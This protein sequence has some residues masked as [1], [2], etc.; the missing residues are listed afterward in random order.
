MKF[1]IKLPFEIMEIIL[2]NESINRKIE[3]LKVLNY[4]IPLIYY[5]KLYLNEINNIKNFEKVK[6]NIECDECNKKADIVYNPVRMNICIDCYYQH[7]KYDE[8]I[9]YDGHYNNCRECN[10]YFI[11]TNVIG[12]YNDRFYKFY[13]RSVN[14][15]KFYPDDN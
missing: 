2:K 8:N 7:Y 13:L 6:D 15:N 4:Q 3:I 11:F 1:Q 12:D 10:R 5:K 9:N 14:Y